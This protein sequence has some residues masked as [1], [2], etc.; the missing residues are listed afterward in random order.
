MGYDLQ[1]AFD[2]VARAVHD[3]LNDAVLQTAEDIVEDVEEQ[4]AEPKSGTHWPGQPRPSSAPGEAPAVQSGDTQASYDAQPEGDLKAAAF[5]NSENA[6]RMEFGTV[7]IAPR[8]S[9]EPA[10]NRA[11]ATIEE[12]HGKAVGQAI[13]RQGI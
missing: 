6:A 9:L 8:P 2:E 10:S 12:K 5:S 4:M 7:F 1:S 3:A 13:E 11:A